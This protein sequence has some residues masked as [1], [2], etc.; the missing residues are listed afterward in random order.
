MRTDLTYRGV[1]SRSKNRQ[2]P[3]VLRENWGFQPGDC[4]NIT[5]DFRGISEVPDVSQD[6]FA[7]VGRRG[8]IE[9]RLPTSWTNLIPKG[10]QVQYIAKSVYLVPNKQLNES[11]PIV[12]GVANV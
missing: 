11:I 6:L 8:S 2:N 7:Y 3:L 10:Y 9:V 4:V 1:Y 12:R 5:M